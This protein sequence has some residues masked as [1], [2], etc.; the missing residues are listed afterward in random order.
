MTLTK[1]TVLVHDQRQPRTDRNVLR[2]LQKLP[3]VAGEDVVSCRHSAIRARAYGI[4]GSPNDKERV[5]TVLP[6]HER[7]LLPETTHLIKAITGHLNLTHAW[8]EVGFAVEV[9]QK[10]AG[11]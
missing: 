6:R 5:T 3:H 9:V 1:Q 7:K 11:L 2:V 10:L 4:G 8:N